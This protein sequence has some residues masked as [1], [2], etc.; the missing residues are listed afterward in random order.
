MKWPWVSRTTLEIVQAD[1]DWFRAQYVRLT[2]PPEPKKPRTM[3]GHAVSDEQIVNEAEQNF[4]A[5]L[6]D[7]FVKQGVSRTDAEREATRIRQ[8][9][10]STTRQH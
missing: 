7:D 8:E 10:M 4:V 5:R 9:T 2:T 3:P 1:R 6:R